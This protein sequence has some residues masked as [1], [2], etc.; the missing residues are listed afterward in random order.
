MYGSCIIEYCCHLD[1]LLVIKG[2]V[3]FFSVLLTNRLIHLSLL[4]FSRLFLTL[5]SLMSLPVILF[6]LLI[7]SMGSPIVASRVIVIKMRSGGLVGI[8]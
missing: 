2:N 5:L 7:N 4:I 3:L 6:D 1:S 8:S